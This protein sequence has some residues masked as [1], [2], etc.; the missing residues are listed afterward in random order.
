M[1]QLTRIGD[2]IG[3]FVSRDFKRKRLYSHEDEDVESPVKKTKNVSRCH[4]KIRLFSIFPTML[5]SSTLNL[6]IFT[7]YFQANG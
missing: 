4:V 7:S 2:L 3:S 5:L 6:R 1:A